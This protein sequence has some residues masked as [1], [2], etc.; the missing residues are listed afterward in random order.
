MDN[1]AGNLNPAPYP[2]C[3]Y[4]WT[5]GRDNA[6]DE[7]A[8]LDT[9]EEYELCYDENTDMAYIRECNFSAPYHIDLL[10]LKC[11]Y[12]QNEE[13]DR[14]CI[15]R[16]GLFNIVPPLTTSDL[17]RFFGRADDHIMVRIYNGKLAVFGKFP[18]GRQAILLDPN[19]NNDLITDITH[20]LY[21]TTGVRVSSFFINTSL[22]DITQQSGV[23]SPKFYS[24]SKNKRKRRNKKNVAIKMEEVSRQ[25]SNANLGST[26]S[27]VKRNFL[28]KLRT[29]HIKISQQSG[30]DIVGLL[31]KVSAVF[32]LKYADQPIYAALSALLLLF[33]GSLS[34]SAINLIKSTFAHFKGEECTLTMFIDWCK[35]MITNIDTFKN[36]RYAKSFID[37]ISK[38]FTTFISPDIANYFG[39]LGNNAIVDKVM[40]I[41][42]NG[43]NPIECI[44]HSI[45]YLGNGVDVFVKTGELTGFL[46]TEMMGEMLMESINEIR[47]NFLLYKNGDMEYITGYKQYDLFE[48]IDTF[49]TNI[50]D[51][52]KSKRNAELRQLDLWEKEVSTMLMYI[53]KTEAQAQIRMQPYH[54]I[55]TAGSGI[56]KSYLTKLLCNAMAIRNGIPYGKD[57]TYYLCQ[58]NKFQ[59]GW[60]NHNTIVIIDDASFLHDDSNNLN[61]ADWLI[62]S[63]NN[64]PH[65]LLGAGVE[66]KHEC[67]NRSLF[68]GWTS[69]SFS[70]RFEEKAFN[71]SALHRRVNVHMVARVRDK[72]TK[73]L[74]YTDSHFKSSQIDYMKM[75]EEQR[76]SLA[77]DA[78]VFDNYVCEILNTPLEIKTEFS[79]ASPEVDNP[80]R[81]VFAKVNGVEMKGLSLAQ[82][83][84]FLCN[85][86]FQFFET[87]KQVLEMDK[88]VNDASNYCSHGYPKHLPKEGKP[89][90]L[91]LK[92]SREGFLR[93]IKIE[94]NK[95][96]KYTP[97]KVSP[98][99]ELMKEFFSDRSSNP[100]L[101]YRLSEKKYNYDE[102]Y[103][104]ILRKNLPKRIKAESFDYHKDLLVRTWKVYTFRDVNTRAQYQVNIATLRRRELVLKDP[105]GLFTSGLYFSRQDGKEKPRIRYMKKLLDTILDGKI[106]HIPTRI[107]DAKEAL[108]VLK[109]IAKALNSTLS[110]W[111]DEMICDIFDALL[112]KLLKI[113]ESM[114]ANPT[115]YIPTV[116]EG[117]VVGAYAHIKHPIYK[118]P[119]ALD[120][121]QYK[122]DVFQQW[123]YDPHLVKSVKP[124][125][126][127]TNFVYNKWMRSE[128]SLERLH[129]TARN[130]LDFSQFALKAGFMLSNN[131]KKIK[132][133]NPSFIRD[134]IVPTCGASLIITSF[135][136]SLCKSFEQLYIET[137]MGYEVKVEDIP[138]LDAEEKVKYYA[139]RKEIMVS[140]ITTKANIKYSELENLTARN[141][142]Y[143]KILETDEIDNVFSFANKYLYCAH[144]FAVKAIGKTMRLTKVEIPSTDLPGNAFV[145]FTLHERNIYKCDGDLCII[146]TEKHMDHMRTKNLLDYLPSDKCDDM[147]TGQLYYKDKLGKLSKYDATHIYY[148]NSI[149][150]DK[151]VP[152]FQAYVY[153][154]DSFDGLC[155]AVLLDQTHK[156][157]QLLGMHVGGNIEGKI[158]VA[159][160]FKRE[161]AEEA[162][163]HFEP[164]GIVIQLG[165]DNLDRFGKRIH[166]YEFYKKSAF[167]D[168]VDRID[169]VELIG[170]VPSRISPKA[171]VVYTPIAGLVKDRFNLDITWGPAP[172]RHGGDKRHGV[173]SLVRQFAN[174][175]TL[176]RMDLLYK[177][178]RDYRERIMEP[179]KNN[180]SYWK[181]E[182]RI[183]SEFETV[184]GVPGKKFLGSMNMSSSFGAHLP[185]NKNKHADQ[186]DGAWYFK[187]YVMDEYHKQLNQFKSGLCTPEMVV[188]ML[189][190]EATPQRKIDIGKARYFY[191]SS[192]VMQMIIRQYLLTT[193]RYW[194]I[195]CAYTECSVG[196][197]PHCDDWDKFVK[198]I[199]K[200]KHFIALD[201]V[202]CDLVS[203]F[204][205]VSSAIDTLFI[206]ILETGE[207][208]QEDKNVLACIKH[209][210]L[211]TICDVGGDL[212][213]LHGIIPSGTPLTSMLGSI[214]NSLNYRMAYYYHYP[215]SKV[216]LHEIMVLRTYGDDS[217]AGV[218]PEYPLMNIKS[219]LHAWN[220][221][222]IQGTDIH[223]NKISNID[224]YALEELE[225]L[226]RGMVYKEDFGHY[227]APLSK[228]SMFKALSCHVPTKSVSIEEL[229]GQCV[230]N[231]LL[232]AK[233]HGREF[234]ETS[235][236]K[237]KDIMLQSDLLR[238]CNSL[239]LSY[240]EVIKIWREQ[241]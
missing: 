33:Q 189:K 147:M 223:K 182:I 114:I 6:F 89:C 22:G 192:T 96:Y 187:P 157:S 154:T 228:D 13:N 73:S 238:F 130:P 135:I 119:L 107:R 108:D 235:R 120:W 241:L 63:A 162:M 128:S 15:F 234:Y 50:R 79:A 124:R 218:S 185:G 61:L 217:A 156:G 194:C 34:L 68:E 165:L 56:S 92:E 184:N 86:S 139:A 103:S 38:A 111:F 113:I 60:K 47:T 17:F 14:Y 118:I 117:T 67:F 46:Q 100:A 231:F 94:H 45:T 149:T 69:N 21:D 8:Y 137:Q 26:K 98:T 136:P 174:K 176:K 64:I 28:N 138:K 74:S 233:F 41:F 175:R 104:Y 141:L 62:R 202:S 54:F 10:F 197:N 204:E 57:H 181:G 214:V 230:D 4:L 127:T 146:Y 196:I 126:D 151:S 132:L 37:F 191:M 109:D 161:Q 178:N 101:R 30:K 150:N 237:L 216:L 19:S 186:I 77:P 78:W 198:C 35:S 23:E 27:H 129:R 24:R 87:Q 144:H 59:S 39:K 115:H 5:I 55:L 122:R 148:T 18:T 131:E 82:Q 66:E 25:L 42:D 155:G 133:D 226:K 29:Q 75:T 173:R 219:I 40:H 43:C 239:D 222:G 52:K 143:C 83:I 16:P 211:Y 91:C 170:S 227:V 160:I 159:V 121:I 123:L 232:E 112:N 203:L 209:T 221:I 210:I 12:D 110:T 93:E 158:G 164:L 134:V 200:Y 229:T 220:D 179:Y 106:T 224:Y 95:H 51:Y 215:N 125:F 142:F 195:N 31:E 36:N 201:L 207:L 9:I 44:L 168:T 183:L 88:K 163:K 152:E 240:D 80:Y 53:K 97:L 212:V 7:D 71:V 72:Y 1:S 205:V 199:T 90:S 11:F 81:F 102:L 180:T 49:L 188:A 116:L 236:E 153:K 76:N 171:K 3:P 208:T 166:N 145:E 20:L 85:D 193:T 177:A 65:E 105:L 140:P 32:L 225:F 2:D 70:Q 84:E 58:S 213:V 99:A 48:K 206:P 167:L 172:F 169:C 190:N